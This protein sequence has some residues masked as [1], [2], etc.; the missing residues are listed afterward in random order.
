V[1]DT[2]PLLHQSCDSATKF[3][4]FGYNATIFENNGG[5]FA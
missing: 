5:K 2:P 1:P 4:F 3:D